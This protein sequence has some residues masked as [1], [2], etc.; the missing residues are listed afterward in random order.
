LRGEELGFGAFVE[1]DGE[2]EDNDERERERSDDDEE[3]EEE[4]ET[5]QK[6]SSSSSAYS[7]SSSSDCSSDSSDDDDHEEITHSNGNPILSLEG[8]KACLKHFKSYSR[9]LLSNSSASNVASATDVAVWLESPV[10]N[11]TKVRL[12]LRT[13]PLA[14]RGSSTTS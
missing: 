6:T 9:Y 4:E 1:E 3:E 11:E 12:R 5:V 7:S 2:E 13:N 8:L 14:A 10:F